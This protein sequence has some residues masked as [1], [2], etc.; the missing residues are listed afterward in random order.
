[1]EHFYR[2]Q[3]SKSQS[4]YKGLQTPARSERAPTSLTL[5]SIA[6]PSAT[7]SSYTGLP[8]VFSV[9][10]PRLHSYPR[11]LALAAPGIPFSLPYLPLH[12]ILLEYHLLR[13]VPQNH[14]FKTLTSVSHSPCFFSLRESLIYLFTVCLSPQDCGFQE[15]RNLGL[16]GLLH[17][18]APGTAPGIQ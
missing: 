16:P 4:S 9:G 12:Q 15:G 1:M 7:C 17:T 8:A 13:E 6:V 10:P 14:L 11:S 3:L 2:I 5:S 18:P